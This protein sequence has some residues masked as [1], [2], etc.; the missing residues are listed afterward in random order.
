M[1]GTTTVPPYLD[2]ASIAAAVGASAGAQEGGQKGAEKGAE[3]AQPFAEAA[4]EAR[5]AAAEAAGAAA[6]SKGSAEAAATEAVSQASVASQK[7]A[8]AEAKALAADEAANR[9]ELAA[10]Q[11]TTASPIYPDVETGLASVDEGDTFSVAGAGD[12]YAILYRK[13]SATA[14]EIGRYPSQAA[15]DSAVAALADIPIRAT[16]QATG[17]MVTGI[18]KR[19][20]AFWGI[21]Q[22]G[23]RLWAAGQALTRR[24]DGTA[25]WERLSGGPGLDLS[26]AGIETDG[27]RI[28][29]AG[30][31]LRGMGG[32]VQNGR[33]VS[34]AHLDAKFRSI[35][36]YGPRHFAVSGLWIDWDENGSWTLRSPRGPLLTV[37]ADGRIEYAESRIGMASFPGAALTL[38]WGDGRLS[39]FRIDPE[40]G[41][42]RLLGRDASDGQREPSDIRPF[43]SDTLWG[44]EGVPVSIYLDGLLAD[45]ADMP[46]CRLTVTSGAGSVAGKDAL[47]AGIGRVDVD[48]AKL[49]ASAQL[50]VHPATWDGGTRAVLP[51]AVRAAPRSPAVAPAPNVLLLGDSITNRSAAWLM[52]QYLTAWGYAPSFVGTLRGTSGDAS[53]GTTG[54]LLGEGREGHQ[55]EDF[56][57]TRTSR[58]EP[59]AAGQEASYLAMAKDDAR[60]LIPWLRAEAS[61]DPEEDVRNGYVMDWLY[62]QSRFGGLLTIPT[63]D[64]VVLG[65]GTNNA[66]YSAPAGLYDTIYAADM[67][68]YRRLRAAWPNVKIIRML[69]GASRSVE[70]DALWKSA[71][72]PMIRAMRKAIADT[73]SSNIVLAPTWAMAGQDV[74]YSLTT[75]TPDP[76]TGALLT[77][78]N[79]AT[80][81]IHAGRAELWRAVAGYVA[82]AA[83]P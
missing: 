12:T 69:P 26:D 81:P 19:G 15:L 53:S 78:L 36:R 40:D 4:D 80:H 45:R 14:V 63:P 76:D 32:V 6:A 72:I 48:V 56:D 59:L 64:I 13:V 60:F 73:A 67:L 52:N 49:S 47:A 74:G 25:R 28:G 71:Y 75:T 83:T 82:V 55:T 65:L 2:I 57:Y 22:L 68:M 44:V 20:R 35:F 24:A 79:D 37:P 61:G 58:V 62:Y 11:A 39:A 18:D 66:I 33:Y 7:A 8:D 16:A 54:G 43:F 5:R 42:L 21:D 46:L 38:R 10:I 70:K 23:K 31:A 34:F 51:L 77:T 30:G 41:A 1:S 9:S 3:A 17:A 29:F 50:V 27:P